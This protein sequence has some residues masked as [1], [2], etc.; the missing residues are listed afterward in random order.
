M[1]I[2][3]DKRGFDPKQFEADMEQYITTEAGLTSQEADAF[4]PLYREM[5][6]EQRD[7]FNEEQRDR[8]FDENSEKECKEFILANDVRDIKVKQ[9]IQEYHKKF[10]EVLPATKVW[11]VLRAEEKFH[12]NM[13]KRGAPRK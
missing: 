2:A 11:R 6:Q 1:A 9:L 13:F 10:L 7:I 8:R 12:R 5:R 3:Q 4:F